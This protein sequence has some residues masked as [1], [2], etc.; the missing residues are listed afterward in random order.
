MKVLNPFKLNEWDIKK[1][2]SIVFLLQSLIL[3][4]IFWNNL[5][6]IN[7]PILRPLAGFIYLT[8]IPGYLILRILKINE[9]NS[10]ES[11]LYAIGLS[12]STLMFSAFLLNLLLP[13]LS[14][15]K[16]ISFVPL[17]FT[18]SVIIIILI[19][20]SIIQ[21]TDFQ[22]KNIELNTSS[23]VPV[24]FLSL[25][26]FL[27]IIGT[28]MVN[29]YQSNVIL[30]LL[31]NIISIVVLLISFNKFI[32]K[33]LYPFTIFLVS[34]AILFQNSLISMYLWGW[35]IHG[36]YY[37]ATEVLKN[38]FWNWNLDNTYN[39]VLS[40]NLLSVYY[41]IICGINISWVLKII[42]PII[43]S[44]LPLGIYEI[45][46]NQFNS[47]RIAF[48]SAFF[49]VS[50]FVFFT[51]MLSL[52]RQEI[53][54]IFLVLIILILLDNK[55]NKT[56]NSFMLVIFSFSLVVSH[57]TTSYIF[58]FIIISVWLL[59]FISNNDKIKQ[60]LSK[61]TYENLNK[62][63]KIDINLNFIILIFVLTVTWYSYISK[64]SAFESLINII[65]QV[66]SNIYG[67]FLNPES[68]Q[69]LAIIQNSAVS[70]LHS[71]FK[72]LQLITQFLI[73]IGLIS[74]YLNKCKAKIN[75]TYLAFL[76]VI[77]LICVFAII[78]PYVSGSIN[79]SRMYHISLIIL[80]PLAIIG[81]IMI[82]KSFY[83]LFNISLINYLT[84]SLKILGCFFVVFLFFNTGLVYEVFGDHPNSISLSQKS[85]N[86]YGD[87]N[88]K[89]VL[90]NSL[91]TEYDVFG[92]KW[93]SNYK[94]DNLMVFAD[95]SQ[96]Y[97]TI[98]SYGN[99]NYYRG[100]LRLTNSSSQKTG[101]IYLSYLNVKHNLILAINGTVQIYDTTKYSLI[102]SSNKIYSNG[103]SE[104]RIFN[105]I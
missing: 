15:L 1:I 46:K 37:Y 89:I 21:K 10:V 53:A 56:K 43:F 99:I 55:L 72:Y 11:L 105:I 8:F 64:S 92:A 52:A 26:P 62:T 65:S 86:L 81:G 36:E 85:I 82:I 75:K 23:L 7:I 19:I 91:T 13:N 42:Y 35:D 38:G 44:L 84:T 12:I 66:T 16:P 40:T 68:S 24:A 73:F 17:F 94:N 101:Y 29:F 79:T 83:S 59:L 98:F 78:A 28:Y 39:G 5:N 45:V 33:N 69:A 31:I 70:P 20:T 74:I 49:C 47:K 80:A 6:I 90:Y 93:I 32:P 14:Y 57:Y 76:T 27:S 9:L 67:E 60:L 48:L 30:I 100:A 3:F 34:I 104:I 2:I 103:Y 4:L 87:E 88:D 96:N 95:A 18:I 22:D 97:K 77:F 51:E 50:F 102:S 41:S 25:I 63:K 58:A 71:I 61:I 54:E